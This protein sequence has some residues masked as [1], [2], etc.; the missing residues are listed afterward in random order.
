VSTFQH[1]MTCEDNALR[2]GD[3]NRMQASSRE[4]SARVES[5]E[6]RGRGRRSMRG[7]ESLLPSPS[8]HTRVDLCSLRDRL[9]LFPFYI[10]QTTG[11]ET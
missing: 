6:D 5:E 9:G 10:R 1:G 8:R 11:T 4:A 2:A 3:M 7:R